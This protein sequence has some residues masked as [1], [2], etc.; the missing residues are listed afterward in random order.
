VDDLTTGM[1]IVEF[2]ERVVNP[3]N[4]YLVLFMLL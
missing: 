4:V 1:G 2:V 3:G